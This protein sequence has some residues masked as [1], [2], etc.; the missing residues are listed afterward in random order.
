MAVSTNNGIT[1][2]PM[3]AVVLG[4]HNKMFFAYLEPCV[5]TLS[6]YSVCGASQ[7]TAFATS[8]TQ[9]K[10]FYPSTLQMCFRVLAPLFWVLPILGMYP[11]G[12]VCRNLGLS[13]QWYWKPLFRQ[14]CLCYLLINVGKGA[15]H[16][17]ILGCPSWDIWGTYS[18]SNVEKCFAS[19]EL[20]VSD[21]SGLPMYRYIFRGEKYLKRPTVLSDL[22]GVGFCCC[23]DHGEYFLIGVNMPERTYIHAL[24]P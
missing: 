20:Y 18:F 7:Q 17:W 15:P 10:G 19:P 6:D 16:S 8:V 3:F 1:I 14:V 2:V 9:R 11:L 24:R 12:C 23:C 22:G 4:T 13:M 21:F 5:G